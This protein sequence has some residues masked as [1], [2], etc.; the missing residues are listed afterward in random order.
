AVRRELRSFAQI[1]RYASNVKPGR[2]IYD[3]KI[4]RGVASAARQDIANDSGVSLSIA[5][6]QTIQRLTLKFEIRRLDFE[7]AEAAVIGFGDERF[8]GDSDFVQS[9]YAVNNPCAFGSE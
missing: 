4:A 5:T 8:P 2:G 6:R 1:C 7:F 3:H 9:V